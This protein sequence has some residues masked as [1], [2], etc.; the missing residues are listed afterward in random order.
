MF[1]LRQVKMAWKSRKRAERAGVGKQEYNSIPH[2]KRGA[3]GREIPRFEADRR[4]N[5]M[6]EINTH[7]AQISKFVFYKM[8]SRALQK[9]QI[10]L[11]P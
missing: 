6:R 10:Y 5:P 2:P 11:Y 1:F 7:N 3:W 9:L 8:F 4:N